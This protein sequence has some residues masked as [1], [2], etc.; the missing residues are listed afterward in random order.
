VLA[1]LGKR[2]E[3]EEEKESGDREN[4]TVEI[5]KERQECPNCHFARLKRVD[6]D[7]FCPVCGYRHKRCG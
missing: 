3:T 5:L 7:I 2:E 6:G 1:K 4:F